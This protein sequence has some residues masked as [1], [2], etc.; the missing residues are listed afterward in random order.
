MK[1]QEEIMRQIQLIESLID[2]AKQA[3][4]LEYAFYL[5]TTLDTLRWV[6]HTEQKHERK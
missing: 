1:T 6:L 4:Q 3:H 2:N 5:N